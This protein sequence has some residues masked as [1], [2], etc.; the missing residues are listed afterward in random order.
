MKIIFK[1]AFNSADILKTGTRNADLAVI[2]FHGTLCFNMTSGIPAAVRAAR[3]VCF[4]TGADILMHGRLDIEGDKY[5]STMIFHNGEIVGVS[6]CI[7]NDMYT[8]GSAL[9]LYELHGVKC[10][11]AVDRDFMY[12]GADNLFCAGAR[13]I[14]HNTLS[15]LDRDYFGAYK[16]HMR[17]TDGFYFGLFSDCALIG[18]RSLRLLPEEGMHEIVLPE[19]GYG[20]SRNFLKLSKGE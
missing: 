17:L 5:L 18:D 10:G 14:F 8:Q 20:N 19:R 12:S 4:A 11:I 1:N 15:A 7:T 13:V 9:R 6:D 16:S 2:N 3:E